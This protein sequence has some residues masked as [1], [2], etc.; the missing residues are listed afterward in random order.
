MFCF[1]GPE[2]CGIVTLPPGIEPVPLALED[3]VLITASPGKS[4]IFLSFLSQNSEKRGMKGRGEKRSDFK[5]I[6][7]V[8]SI[9]CANK[10][11]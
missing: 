8:E 5:D 7:K 6:Q 4:P 9:E 3:K 11:D 2:A 10:Y 1:L